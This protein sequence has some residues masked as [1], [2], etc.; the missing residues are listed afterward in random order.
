MLAHCTSPAI[1]G[2]IHIC[3]IITVWL[4]LFARLLR[5]ALVGKEIEVRAGTH[6]HTTYI[7]NVNKIANALR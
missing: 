3:I 1:H 6:L 5:E 4:G 2:N 7:S